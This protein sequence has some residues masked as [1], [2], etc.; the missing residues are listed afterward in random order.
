MRSEGEDSNGR[1][2]GGE[3]SREEGGDVNSEGAS[4]DGGEMKEE[5]GSVK[6]EKRC[7]EVKSMEF[8]MYVCVEH[9]PMQPPKRCIDCRQF[10]DDPSFKVFPGD[11]ENAVRH[12]HSNSLHPSLPLLVCSLL[13]CSRWKSLSL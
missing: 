5:K 6:S 2:S 10:L 11:P 4:S 8:T 1:G 13:V 12:L 3:G 9:S 7:A